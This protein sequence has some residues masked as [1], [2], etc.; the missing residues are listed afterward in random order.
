VV[1][2]FTGTP[3]HWISKTVE[4]MLVNGLLSKSKKSNGLDLEQLNSQMVQNIKDRQRRV[5][6]MVKVE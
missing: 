2:V 5:F 4:P 1:K 3:E 6:S